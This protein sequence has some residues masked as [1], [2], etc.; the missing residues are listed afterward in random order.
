MALPAL[1]YAVT[2]PAAILGII[3][4]ATGTGALA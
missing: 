2:Y 3:G 1:A 4:T